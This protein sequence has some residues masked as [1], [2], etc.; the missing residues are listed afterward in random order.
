MLERAL[1][2]SPNHTN[3]MNWLAGAYGQARGLRV[4]V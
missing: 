2:L 3:A 1:E 4:A